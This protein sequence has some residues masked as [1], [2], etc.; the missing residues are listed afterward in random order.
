MCVCDWLFDRW[1]QRLLRP[2]LASGFEGIWSFPCL[3]TVMCEM[4]LD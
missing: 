1:S 4:G 3:L 2:S